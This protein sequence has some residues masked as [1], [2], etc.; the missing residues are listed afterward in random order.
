MKAT[1]RLL[2]AG[3]IVT[4]LLSGFVGPAAASVIDRINTQPQESKVASSAQAEAPAQES[5]SLVSVAAAASPILEVPATRPKVTLLGRI[6]KLG[7]G[8]WQ[9]S[10]TLVSFKTV[11]SSSAFHM[12]DFVKLSGVREADG[13]ISADEFEI[14]TEME[15]QESEHPAAQGQEKHGRMGKPDSSGQD[16][17]YNE[18]ESCSGTVITQGDDDDQY[19]QCSDG[20]YPDDHEVEGNG[21]D[22]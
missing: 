20:Q 17:D 19:E 11:P 22:D 4:A 18:N 15:S 21:H 1:P 7:P 10:G 13:S 14:S 16:D 12:G 5:A 8:L 2:M 3:Y 6:E 9:V